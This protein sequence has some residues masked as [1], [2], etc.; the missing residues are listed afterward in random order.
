ML[1]AAITVLSERDILAKLQKMREENS[2]LRSKDK[3]K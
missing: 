2:P 3:R 1:N